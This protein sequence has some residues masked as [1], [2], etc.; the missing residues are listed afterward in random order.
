MSGLSLGTC[1]SNLKSIALTV[2]N[3][4]DW[5]VCCTHIDR[6]TLTHTHIEQ[7]QYLRHSLRS[8]GR[9]KDSLNRK[10]IITAVMKWWHTHTDTQTHAQTQWWDR[11]FNKMSILIFELGLPLITALLWLSQ[12]LHLMLQPPDLIATS[13]TVTRV[14]TLPTNRHAHVD[15]STTC[16]PC[17][18]T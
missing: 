3:W 7:K 2:L 4:S 17:K 12:M 16:V 6:N 15:N 18:T 11:P 8:R 13:H 10:L 14:L 1:M 9:D 5:L